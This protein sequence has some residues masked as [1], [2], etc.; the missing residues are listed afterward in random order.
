MYNIH[1]W[2]NYGSQVIGENALVEIDC[3]ALEHQYLIVFFLEK[4][5][6]KGSNRCYYF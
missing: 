1:I 2:E 6:Q 4:L 5:L 3:K